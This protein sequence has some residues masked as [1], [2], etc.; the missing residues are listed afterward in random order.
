MGKRSIQSPLLAAESEHI[1]DFTNHI[2][3]WAVITVTQPIGDKILFLKSEMQKSDVI[4]VKQTRVADLEPLYMVKPLCIKTTLWSLLSEAAEIFPKCI[5]EINQNTSVWSG[6]SFYS[7]PTHTSTSLRVHW[8]YPYEPYVHFQRFEKNP[9][10]DIRSTPWHDTAKDIS[11]KHLCQ[12]SP[13]HS[14]H[15]QGLFK[16]SDIHWK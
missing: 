13:E 11:V 9:N 2:P 16:E 7:H 10:N 8:D 15:A 5:A 1:Q 3:S 14:N 4:F 6:V 12:Q